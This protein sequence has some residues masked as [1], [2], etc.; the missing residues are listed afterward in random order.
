MAEARAIGRAVAG[1]ARW[2]R[3]RSCER[4]VDPDTRR[5]VWQVVVAVPRRRS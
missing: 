5:S 2:A 4:I 1:G 3:V